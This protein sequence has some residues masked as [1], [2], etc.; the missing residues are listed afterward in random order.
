MATESID[1]NRLIRR[2][3]WLAAIGG[4]LGSALVAGVFGSYIQ[5][6]V[7]QVTNQ[8]MKLMAIPSDTPVSVAGGS[9]ITKS[10]DSGGW[11]LL[12]GGTPYG[13]K[14]AIPSAD[15][16]KYIYIA[17]ED[18]PEVSLNESTSWEVD[19]NDRRNGMPAPVPDHGIKLCP[20]V[21]QSS[22]IFACAPAGTPFS[23]DKFVYLFL[24]DPTDALSDALVDDEYIPGRMHHRKYFQDN[25]GG[26]PCTGC[27]FIS[28]IVII[29]GAGST[30][31]PVKNGVGKVALYN[32]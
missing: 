14:T 6:E 17:T 24:I 26:Q 15:Y 11:I 22:G 3:G 10:K 1:A 32:K 12:S 21:T 5:Q 7:G 23:P 2:V 8:K 30:S 28:Q 18:Q 25:N 13:F 19:I 16:K 4:A 9:I 29:T 27:D 31:Y 20:E